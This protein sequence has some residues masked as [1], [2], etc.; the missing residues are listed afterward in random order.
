MKNGWHLAQISRRMSS[1]VERVTKL[2]PHA[3]VTVTTLYTGW[4]PLFM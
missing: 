3:Q 4:I 2:S 1:F